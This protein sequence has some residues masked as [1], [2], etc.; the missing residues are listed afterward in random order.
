[1]VDDGLLEIS[2]LPAPTEVVGTLKSLLGGG[3]LETL[4]VRARLPWV[5]INSKENLDINLDGEPLQGEN[6][7]FSA[8]PKALKVHLPAGS[9]LLSRRLSQ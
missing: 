5:E 2:I 9:P 7:R 8:M 4:F 6:L 1:M 3:G